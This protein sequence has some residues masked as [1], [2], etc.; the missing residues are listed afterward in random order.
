MQQHHNQ[1]RAIGVLLRRIEAE[2]VQATGPENPARGEVSEVTAGVVWGLLPYTV[3]QIT[4][5]SEKAA[6]E[7]LKK[8]LDLNHRAAGRPLIFFENLQEAEDARWRNMNACRL[9]SGTFNPATRDSIANALDFSANLP[10]TFPK[11]KG[12]IDPASRGLT[13]ANTPYPEDR[14]HSAWYYE[15][16]VLAA[17]DQIVEALGHVAAGTSGPLDL[18]PD[19]D[20]DTGDFV[21]V[22]LHDPRSKTHCRNFPENYPASNDTAE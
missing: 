20:Y 1:K 4:A 11:A 19:F 15:P 13:T 6:V 16:D 21:Y 12:T 17:F 22:P 10:E 14:E 5:A 8:E 9:L 7:G 2:P 3:P 18:V